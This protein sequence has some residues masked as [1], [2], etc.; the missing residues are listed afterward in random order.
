MLAILRDYFASQAVLEV[1]TPTLSRAANT[2]PNIDSITANYTGPCSPADGLMYL[3]TSPEFPMK[4]LLASGSGAIYQICKVYRDGELGRYHNPE[5]SLLEWYR[6]GFDQHRLMAE[7][8]TIVSLVLGE[9]PTA[10]RTVTYQQAFIDQAGFDPLASDVSVFQHCLQQHGVNV[11]GMQGASDDEWL[12]LIL[13]QIVVPGF[14]RGRVFIYNYPASQA[15]LA[16]L[17]P[18]DN[19]FA[20]RFE[21]YV[22]GIELANGFQ[23][24]T[25]AEQQQLRFAADNTRR[26]QIAKPVLPVDEYFIDALVAGI[27][28]CAGV[29]LGLDRLLMLKRGVDDIQQVLAFPFSKA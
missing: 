6:P 8:E 19:R 1:D 24:L 18:S 3:H 22:D 11:V 21:L 14:G 5:F 12:D 2:D 15:S 17:D 29:A 28:A 7:V 10:T 25:D 26:Q 9:A 13:D 23:E 4:R 16:R 27:P 20:Q